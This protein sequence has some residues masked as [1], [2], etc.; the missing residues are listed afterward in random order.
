MQKSDS[1]GDK[2]NEFI[3][4]PI[5]MKE[6][7]ISLVQTMEKSDFNQNSNE[8][9]NKNESK[10]IPILEFLKKKKSHLKSSSAPHSKRGIAI[11]KYQE[12]IEL[13]N[14]VKTFLEPMVIN[15]IK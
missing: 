15:T 6:K 3:L 8:E 1:I 12:S 7:I 2:Q 10:F 4:E 13:E 11:R 14:R 5:H 9:S